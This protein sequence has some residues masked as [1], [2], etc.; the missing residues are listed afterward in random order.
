MKKLI[1]LFQLAIIPFIGFCQTWL[2]PHTAI[3]LPNVPAHSKLCD[4]IAANG[5]N[6]IGMNNM[7]NAGTVKTMRNFHQMEI[8][9]K[10]NFFPADGILNADTCSCSNVWA[11]GGGCTDIIQPGT[12][13]GFESTKGYYCAWNG[14][15]FGFTEMHSALES[16]FPKYNGACPNTTINR[17]Y[18]NK[19]YSL[20]EFGG[21]SNA[22]VNFKN[23]VLSFLK[24]NCPKDLNKPALVDVLEIGN[25][26]WGDPYPGKDGYHQLLIGTVAACREYYGT[27]NPALWRIELSLAAFRAH[28]AGPGPFGE[29]FYYVDEAIPDTLKHYFS[30]ANIHPYAFNIVQFNSGNLNAGVTETPESN[31]GAFLTFKNMI[32]W[33][34]QKM[35]NAKV[36]ITEFGWNSGVLNDGCGALGES[37][38]AAYYMRAYLLAARY[39]IHRA[40]VYGYTDMNEYPLYCTTG[41]FKDIVNNVAR[42]SYKSIITTA[43]SALKD[44]RF[45]KALSENADQAANGQNGKFVYVFGDSAGTPTHI[46]AWRPVKLGFEDNNY[47]GFSLNYDTIQLPG[48]NM[49]FA[50]NDPY[51]YLGWDNTQ[52]SNVSIYGGGGV[53]GVDGTTMNTN[54]AYVKLTGMPIVIPIHTKGCKY[55]AAGNLVGCGATTV[56][57]Y[58]NNNYNVN[59]YYA[60]GQLSIS[61]GTL[62]G[63]AVLKIFNSIGQEILRKN[64]SIT[65]APA[66]TEFNSAAK[67][68]FVVKIETTEG[69]SFTKKIVVN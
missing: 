8:D 33:K 36:N 14:P 52:N 26:P 63:E 7:L 54:T 9:Y 44:A 60:A 40:F 67:G 3:S 5:G 2:Q 24:T 38:Q 18:P 50:L 19:W 29:Q 39:D 59:I 61:T 32:E 21:L 41:L 69:Y 31:N 62:E 34:N 22:A 68:I 56:N 30:Y 37:T 10:Y 66:Y 48:S 51:F 65:R 46:V 57:N 27:G 20:T 58:L 45:L 55:D 11:N 43:N 1:A 49:N 28:D 4:V 47:P 16:I 25:E 23:Y 17:G 35:P 64:I 6:T 13:S 12:K 42:K 53:V 15:N